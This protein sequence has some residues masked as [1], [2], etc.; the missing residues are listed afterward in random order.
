MKPIVKVHR[1]ENLCDGC[2]SYSEWSE[3]R[4]SLP[5]LFNFPLESVIRK[6]QKNEKGLELK[7]KYQLLF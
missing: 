3:M 6:V 1:D 4:C 2:T 7:G 5:L